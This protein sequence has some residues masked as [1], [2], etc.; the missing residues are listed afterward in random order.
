MF[1]MGDLLNKV[2]DGKGIRLKSLV[3]IN[4]ALGDIS[5]EVSEV[6]DSYF[7]GDGASRDSLRRLYGL[8]NSLGFSGNFGEDSR[9][10]W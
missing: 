5:K 4:K 3:A 8:G 7:R 10:Y 9:M 1:F 2:G 6:V